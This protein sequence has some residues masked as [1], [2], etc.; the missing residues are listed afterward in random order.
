MNMIEARTFRAVC[1]MTVFAVAGCSSAPTGPASSETPQANEL[2]AAA[3]SVPATSSYKDYVHVPGGVFTHKSCVH[4][5]PA[6]GFV[7][8]NQ[9]VTDS[10]G[11]FVMAIPP[12]AYPP[13]IT[14]HSTSSTSQSESQQSS[15]QS[16]S[17]NGWQS[18]TIQYLPGGATTWN[19]INAN[20]VVPG[21]P[22]DTGALQYYFNGLEPSDDSP[23]LQPVL[24]Y[25]NGGDTGGQYWS[26]SA[27]QV[28][29]NGTANY[30][31]PLAVNTGDTL[32]FQIYI[33]SVSGSTYTYYVVPYDNNLNKHSSGGFAQNSGNGGNNFIY[34]FPAVHESYGDN[35][36]E[37][38]VNFYNI[39]QYADTT[40]NALT[41]TYV[42][43]APV[44][45]ACDEGTSPSCFFCPQIASNK[46]STYVF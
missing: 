21:T 22:E 20:L 4:E 5:I 36:C 31:A 44:Q 26:V 43:P 18:A 45:F 1:T 9:N 12:C 13:V 8:E 40:G 15:G 24:Q 33:H 28:F 17:T 23:I 11:N 3:V 37:D 34:Y 42:N 14:R 6:G 25:G 27:Y 39:S 41:Y 2:V 30:T 38:G 29:S 35:D 10:D 16:P 19:L 32:T 7:D 46:E